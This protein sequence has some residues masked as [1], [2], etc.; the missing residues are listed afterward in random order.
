L[1]RSVTRNGD[2]DAAIAVQRELNTAKG[3]TE[4]ISGGK[5]TSALKALKARYEAD[6]R[7]ASKPIQSR[8]ITALEDLQTSL[9]KRG[10]LSSALA[11]RQEVRSVKQNSTSQ[12][13][14]GL[15]QVAEANPK[16]ADL[17]QPRTVWVGDGENARL[18]L[19]ITERRGE[20]FRASFEVG[21]KIIREVSGTIKNGKLTWNARDVHVIKGTRGGDNVGIVNG[22]KIDFE[23]RSATGG[24]GTFTLQR[25]KSP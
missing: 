17:I 16:M 6:M 24:K 21:S 14:G 2:L 18:T 20:T 9:T 8:Y 22:D 19:T 10:D 23:W 4:T 1:L 15:T 12:T 3:K 11:V 25:T 7:T 5:I 13:A